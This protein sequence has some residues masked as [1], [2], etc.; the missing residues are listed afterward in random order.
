MLGHQVS[1][2][3]VGGTSCRASLDSLE[4]ESVGNLPDNVFSASSLHPLVSL[5]ISLKSFKEQTQNR[6]L[7]TLFFLYSRVLKVWFSCA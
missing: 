3:G 5:T 2:F 1:L 6:T 7:K 4:L